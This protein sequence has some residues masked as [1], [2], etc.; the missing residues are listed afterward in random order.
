MGKIEW[1]YSK[2]SKHPA[3]FWVAVCLLSFLFFNVSGFFIERFEIS[4]FEAPAASGYINR[5]IRLALV[6][7]CNL[8]F[9]VAFAGIAFGVVG[10][11]GFF[12]RK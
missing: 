2:R 7:F 9:Y 5:V 3:I 8:F 11:L 12:S 10:M 4:M 6:G 1:L